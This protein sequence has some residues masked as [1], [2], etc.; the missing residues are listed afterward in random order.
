MI[1]F[2]KISIKDYTYIL[3]SEKIAQYPLENRDESKLL[4][5][6]NGKIDDTY[7][8]YIPKHIP[9]DSYI[10][11]NDTKVIL[12]RIHFIKSTGAK[13][14][15]F[16]LSPANND[17]QFEFQ[18][19]GS[20]L[21]KCYI[22]N[23][24][25]WK[26]GQLTK[27]FVFENKSY[28]L[29]AEIKE[30]LGDSFNVQFDWKPGD[31]SFAEVLK[32][33]GLVPLPPYIRREAVKED[34]SK[35]QTIYAENEGSVAA[36]TA[37][38][39]FTEKVI[40]DFKTKNINILKVTLNV[41]AGTFKPVKDEYIIEHKMHSESVC[42]SRKIIEYILENQNKKLIAVGTTSLRT[43]ESLYWFG[44][45]LYHIPDYSGNYLNVQQWQPYENNLEEITVQ[46]SLLSVLQFMERRNLDYL[47]GETSII[48]VPGYDFKIVNGLITNFHL[49]AST[50]LLLIAAFIGDEWKEIYNYAISNNFRF[51]SYGDSSL[52]FRK[53]KNK[54]YERS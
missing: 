17:Y 22:G 6:S 15:I 19:T 7:F 47:F 24:G 2:R 10:V 46:E 43:L 30:L 32:S 50:L 9:D 31:I 51:L 44:F 1:D 38:L 12:S 8:K 21:W 23:V 53:E 14:E 37:G 45:K 20:S 28:T 39:H 26:S 40:D 4:V 29:F 33:V 25:K 3:P 13:I 18:K 54:K 48:I 11:L 27:N 41:G 34:E 36:P 35:Y 5:Y 42:V 52:L 49:S 16:C